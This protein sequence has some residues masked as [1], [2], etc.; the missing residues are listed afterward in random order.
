[1]LCVKDLRIVFT[2][3]I[4]VALVLVALLAITGVIVRASHAH[5][6]HRREHADRDCTLYPRKLLS[7]SERKLY[8]TISAAFPRKHVLVHVALPSCLGTKGH[9]SGSLY[10][11]VKGFTAQFV[12]C[13]KDFRVEAIV[14]IDDGAE[15]PRRLEAAARKAQVLAQAGIAFRAVSLEPMPTRRDII[16]LLPTLAAAPTRADLWTRDVGDVVTDLSGRFKALV[17]ERPPAYD[18][19][20]TSAARR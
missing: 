16:N 8:R 4:G 11:S 1:M 12:V 6:S 7:V 19:E 15:C 2:I 13:A 18:E 3:Q 20:A 10:D 17:M 9:D 14:E 5:R